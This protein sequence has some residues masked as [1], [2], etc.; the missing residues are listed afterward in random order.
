VTAAQSSAGGAPASSIRYQPDERPPEALA[1]GLGL[2]MAILQVAGIDDR[3]R[4]CLVVHGALDARA[5]YDHFFYHGH[6]FFGLLRQDGQRRC[7][8]TECRCRKG[9][10]D[11][12][13]ELVAFEH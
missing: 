3:H 1:F 7:G 8:H 9:S 12:H 13:A 6:A 11:R 5:G 10:L 4:R 2:Q